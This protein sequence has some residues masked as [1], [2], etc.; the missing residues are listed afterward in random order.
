MYI[1]QAS[2]PTAVLKKIPARHRRNRYLEL[3]EEALLRAQFVELRKQLE[4]I[5]DMALLTGMRLGEILGLK[6]EYVNFGSA[7]RRHTV[8]RIGF[9]L[10]PNWLLIEKT[11]NGQ[12]R[13]LP[14]S[15]GVRTILLNLWRQPRAV[16]VFYNPRILK[17]LTTIKAAWET[18][19]ENAGIEDFTF[20]DL[21]HTWSKRAAERGATENTRKNIR[22]HSSGDITSDYAHSTRMAMG[23]AMELVADFPTWSSTKA[24]QQAG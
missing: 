18:A 24:R 12:P 8:K 23:Q 3:D 10:P 9:N 1:A 21:R 2:V 11:K 4:P 19:Y 17:K 7:F 5:F 15:G 6:W 13:M 16:T 20:H 14:M 22:G